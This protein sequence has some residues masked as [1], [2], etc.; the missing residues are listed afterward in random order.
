MLIAKFTNDFIRFEMIY[1]LNSYN[2]SSNRFFTQKMSFKSPIGTQVIMPFIYG[3]EW[4]Y[5]AFANH[6]IPAPI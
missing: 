6:F 3:C 4:P 2:H 1:I 5:Y